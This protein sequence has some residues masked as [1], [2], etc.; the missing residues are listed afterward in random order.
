M[1]Q[2]RVTVLQNSVTVHYKEEGQR[3][4][5]DVQVSSLLFSVTE[6]VTLRSCSSKG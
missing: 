5:E 2:G 4:V 6:K 3:E 1:L